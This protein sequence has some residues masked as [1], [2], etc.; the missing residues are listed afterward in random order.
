MSKRKS[1]IKAES[2]V[3]EIRSKTPENLNPWFRL[4]EH[5]EKRMEVRRAIGL[6][7]FTGLIVLNLLILNG[8]VKNTLAAQGLYYPLAAILVAVALFLLAGLLA[9]EVM[10]WRDRQTYHPL[11]A[12]L[13]IYLIGATKQ[14]TTQEP[15][16]KTFLGSWAGVWPALAA[17]TITAASLFVFSKLI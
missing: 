10:N 13:D 11:L 17:I 15:C 5:H 12:A 14:E 4:L 7:M 8:V 6:R 9:I 16:W 2:I 3:Q 1:Q